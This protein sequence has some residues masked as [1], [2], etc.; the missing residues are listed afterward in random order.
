MSE[1]GKIRDLLNL[2]GFLSLAAMIPSAAAGYMPSHVVVL[3]EENHNLSDILGNSSAPYINSLTSSGALMTQSFNPP[4]LH[5]SQPNYLW[6]FSGSNLGITSDAVFPAD[7]PFTAPNLGAAL[8]AAGDSF[9]GYSEG[10]PGVGFTGAA[11][12]LYARK[13]NP[14]VNWQSNSP[15]PNQLPAS[16]NQ[17]FSAFPTDYSTLPTVS[18]VIPNLCDDMQ[19]ACGGNSIANA[20][21]WLQANIDPFVQWAMNNNSLLILT[22]DES[23]GGDLPVT[24]IFA[25]AGVIPGHYSEHVTHSNILRT[26]EDFYGLVPTGDVVN[27]LSLADSGIFNQASVPEPATFALLGLGLAGLG[28]SRRKQV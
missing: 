28:F 9:T 21:T 25:G 24:T 10:L 27:A 17:P 16:T 13:H 2:A 19:N 14:W 4:G 3:I 6:L 5:P 22:T 12:G 7:P 18:F 15:G 20:D 26:I 8:I 23:H 11:S 1:S